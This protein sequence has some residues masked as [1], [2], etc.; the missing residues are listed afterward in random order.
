MDS[1]APQSP[2]AL[3]HLIRSINSTVFRDENGEV[4]YFGQKVV[5]LRRDVFAV[6]RKEL[7]RVAGNAA[8]VILAIAGQRVGAEEG[9]ALMAK[10]ER[11]GLRNPD[12][13]PSFIG[14]VVEQTNMGY[15]KA[16]VQELNMAATRVQV[17][18]MN[19][20][21]SEPSNGVPSASPSCF[22]LLGYFEGLFSQLLGKQMK[23]SETACRTKGDHFCKFQL[24]QRPS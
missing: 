24:A 3:R 9:S 17:M 23:G 2:E 13:L 12:S 6:I 19:S 4:E 8:N 22:F 1:V 21:E 20:F 15:G 11:L 18:I 10:A 14:A 16:K 5:M 7:M